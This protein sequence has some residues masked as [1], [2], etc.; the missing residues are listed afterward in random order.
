MADAA[1]IERLTAA[2]LPLVT[3][4]TADAVAANAVRLAV[5]VD[6]ALERAVGAA[7]A[8]HAFKLALVAKFPPLSMGWSDE[9][10]ASW[11]Q[12]FIE[13][14]KMLG[15]VPPAGQEVQDG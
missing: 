11:T 7:E 13:L 9:L 4:D 1:R 5:A 12:G 8:Q 14:A 6:A 15:V 2:A 3:G 10:R